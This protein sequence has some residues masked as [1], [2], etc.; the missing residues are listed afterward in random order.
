M[1]PPGSGATRSSVIRAHAL[2]DLRVGARADVAV[3]PADAQAVAAAMASTSP[4]YSCQIPKLEAG[5]PVLVRLVEPAAESGIHADR[6][7]LPGRHPAEL[8]ELVER[9]RV[10]D[11][12][13]LEVVG[14]RTRGHLRG[15][16]DRL[17]GEPGAE[18]ALDL[19]VA[20]GVDATARG[21]GRAARTPVRGIGLH[22]VA[23]GEPERRGEGQRRPRRSLERGAVVDV[24][25]R[26][27]A[28]AHLRGLVGGEERARGGLGGRGHARSSP[29]AGRRSSN[30]LDGNST[31]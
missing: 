20:G 18:R 26:A 25:R 16:L 17:G 19:A 6:H 30:S 2:P 10:V 9:A 15:E 31:P 24:A 1:R 21:R 3:E 22:G 29:E 14:E 4:A 11:D 8:L 28:L 13:A 27:E 7:G 5:P 23:H 12:A